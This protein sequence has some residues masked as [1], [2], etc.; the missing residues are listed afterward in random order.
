MHEAGTAEAALRAAVAHPPELVVLDLGLPDREGFEVLSAL[1]E[2][3]RA[4]VIVL[5]V[6]NR[7]GEKVR[8]FDLGADDYVVKPFGMPE[9]LARVKAALRRQVAVA[10]P[11]FRVGGLEVDLAHR[12]VRVEG[13][14]VRLSPKQYRLL[15]VLVANAGKVV[16]HR[17]LLGEVWGV[18]HRDD[19]QYLRV[20]VRKLRDRL[21]ADPARPRYLLTELGVGYRLRTPDQLA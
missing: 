1:R 11:V 20:F 7:E 12:L 4:P 2:W 14:E 3:S 16:T 21:E 15:Q 10:E 8:A 17:Q 18:A 6:R 13:A 5:S 9:L 19:V